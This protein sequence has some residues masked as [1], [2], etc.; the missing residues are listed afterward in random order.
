MNI[1]GFLPAASLAA[2]SSASSE[3]LVPVLSSNAT[4]G[5][6]PCLL[7]DG[8]QCRTNSWSLEKGAENSTGSQTNSPGAAAVTT[9]ATSEH[10]A[11]V[12]GARNSTRKW[13]SP[14]VAMAAVTLMAM[15]SAGVVAQDDIPEVDDAIP[16]TCSLLEIW[17]N[18]GHF[19]EYINGKYHVGIEED[20][21]LIA[22]GRDAYQKIR[23]PA[24]PSQP[25][26]FLIHDKGKWCVTFYVAAT[27]TMA[28]MGCFNQDVF[29]PGDIAVPLII[30]GAS[31]ANTKVA[32]RKLAYAG[33]TDKPIR[34]EL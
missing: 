9:H 34:N 20:D 11:S 29:N 16:Q 31:D 21:G 18:Q 17:G 33:R 1:I 14:T 12:H 8:T 6:A 19:A 32:C 2:Y 22:N 23:N 28:G 3:R 13:T 7:P 10:P 5:H 4:T 26:M 27:Q 30:A 15:S 25:N 24:K